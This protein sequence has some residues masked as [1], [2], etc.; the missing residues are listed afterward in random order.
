MADAGS[1]CSAHQD[2]LTNPTRVMHDTLQVL[3]DLQNAAKGR[4]QLHSRCKRCLHILI[5]LCSTQLN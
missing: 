4:R 5:L 2:H 3:T 1:P